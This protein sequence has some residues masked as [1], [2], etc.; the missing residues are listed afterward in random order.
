M[1]TALAKLDSPTRSRIFASHTKLFPQ[2][3][4]LLIYRLLLRIKI[5]LLLLFECRTILM[6]RC[7]HMEIAWKIL[8]KNSKNLGCRLFFTTNDS[9][10][11]R[12]KLLLLKI[13]FP[14]ILMPKVRAWFWKIFCIDNKNIICQEYF[15]RIF[16]KICAFKKLL[17]P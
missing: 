10:R 16:S 1:T 12:Q 9:R 14:A 13:I 2:P 6:A 4:C 17:L 5:Q 7:P 3:N 8:P 11:A 15:V